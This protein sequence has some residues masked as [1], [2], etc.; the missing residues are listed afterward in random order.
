LTPATAALLNYNPAHPAAALLGAC[1]VAENLHSFLDFWGANPSFQFLAVATAKGEVVDRRGLVHRN[2]LRDGRVEGLAEVCELLGGERGKL[3]DV[4]G[5]AD[6]HSY[7]SVLVG[8][9]EVSTS[10]TRSS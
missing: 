2:P 4:L 1:Y 6:D 5:L 10:S 9:V 7:C 3:F 8:E